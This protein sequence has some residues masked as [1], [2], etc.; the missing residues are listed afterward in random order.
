[1]YV[2]VFKGAER[3]TGFTATIEGH[4]LP[5]THGPWVLVNRLSM[6]DDD[7]PRPIVQTREC[8]DDIEMHGFHLTSGNRRVTDAFD[9]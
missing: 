9:H 8:L 1:M 6:S 5:A 2:Y 7:D 4:N 3:L